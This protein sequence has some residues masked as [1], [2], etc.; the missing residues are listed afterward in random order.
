M[1]ALESIVEKP[2]YCKEAWETSLDLL[3][4]YAMLIECIGSLGVVEYG[5]PI[6][7]GIR[8]YFLGCKLGIFLLVN[9]LLSKDCLKQL[10]KVRT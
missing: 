2:M 10:M 4:S 6:D 8:V 5:T 3:R 7:R 9:L 1:I